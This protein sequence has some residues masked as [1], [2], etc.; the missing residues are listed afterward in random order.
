MDDVLYRSRETAI[1]LLQDAPLAL[2]SS[3]N[4]LHL[5]VLEAVA[6]PSVC[7]LN[8]RSVPQ[9]SLLRQQVCLLTEACTSKANLT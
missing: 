7:H 5:L 6:T 3:H 8:H 2:Q 4:L 1:Q 9:K